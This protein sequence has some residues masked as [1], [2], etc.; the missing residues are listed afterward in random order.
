MT[1]E[2]RP[3]KF[4][5]YFLIG[6]QLKTY[7]KNPITR[8]LFRKNL[9]RKV[10]SRFSKYYRILSKDLLS[11]VAFLIHDRDVR[12]IFDVGANVGFVTY[13]FQKR[14]PMADIYCF[15]P[16]PNVFN[17]LTQNYVNDKNIHPVH[18]GMADQ[19]GELFFNLNSN[20]G[21]SS[22]LTPTKYHKT[23]QA[24]HQ[25]D[26]VTVPVI[27]I[28]EFS[29]EENITHIDILKLDI[30]GYELKA[31]QGAEKLLNTQKIDIIFTE[32]CILRQYE[33]QVLFHELTAFLENKNYY[34]YNVDSFC[35][36]ETPIRQ[37]VIA[38][39][40]YISSN[41]RKILESNFGIENCGW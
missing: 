9:L 19:S 26:P 16:N 34:L 39:A 32:I 18:K 10:K 21:T 36:Q 11:D 25:L 22:F 4:T 40:V 35:G 30:E 15:E 27:T 6:K 13:Q 41:F 28:D 20:T 37:A 5:P 24:K 38:N 3:K 2:R 23:H 31:L 14:F 1:E 29:Q 8:Y 12:V 33:E 17:K 7:Y